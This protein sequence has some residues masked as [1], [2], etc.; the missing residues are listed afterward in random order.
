[1]LYDNNLSSDFFENV[2]H[3]HLNYWLLSVSVLVSIW[4]F[5]GGDG[6]LVK[7]KYVLLPAELYF[8]W[9]KILQVPS[10]TWTLIQLGKNTSWEVLRTSPKDV[11][12]M[13]LS[14]RL[15]N[16]K[17][18]SYRRPEKVLYQGTSPTDVLRTS[19]V[20][21]MRVSTY[22]LIFNSKVCALPTSWWRLSETSRERPKDILIWFYKAKKRPRDLDFYISIGPGINM[23]SIAL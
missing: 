8:P 15:C 20:D 18:I 2:W 14:G 3:C 21:V 5:H 1:M 11:I 22:C 17:G 7:T 4:R 13:S 10:K 9:I 12:W 19:H 16:A 23:A 6:E